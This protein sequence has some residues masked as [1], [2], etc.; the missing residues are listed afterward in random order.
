M[1]SCTA[2]HNEYLQSNSDKFLHSQI[3]LSVYVCEREEWGLFCVL[4][5]S[6]LHG[7]E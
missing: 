1:N 4:Y 5:L 2:A 7:S 3:L 6:L